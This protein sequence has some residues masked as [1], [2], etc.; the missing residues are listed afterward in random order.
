MSTGF[1]STDRAHS[2][3]YSFRFDLNG[4]S[5][6]YRYDPMQIPVL[7]GARYRVECYCQTTMLPNARPR[8]TAY[9]TDM[10][11]HPLP[12]SC[13]IPNSMRPKMRAK[14]GCGLNVELDAD[15]PQAAY[16]AVELGLLQPA[17]YA[18]RSLGDRRCCPQD[19][20][21]SAWFDAYRRARF[22]R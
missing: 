21:G 7:V 8:L 11:G 5:L 2:G 4:G 6:I 10:D 13:G 15:D 9:F 17:L 3:Q 1:L 14:V 18:P 12:A 16:L 22:R 20:H 19:I